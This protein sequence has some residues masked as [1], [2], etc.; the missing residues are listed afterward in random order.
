MMQVTEQTHDEK[1]KMYMK[2][3]KQKLAEMLIECNRILNAQIEAKNITSNY[4]LADS[5]Q[6]EWHY[7]HSKNVN[8]FYVCKKCLA[9]KVGNF[10]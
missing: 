3:T 1:L 4:V 5:C 6:H 7:S 8:N 2:C 10:H 9:Q